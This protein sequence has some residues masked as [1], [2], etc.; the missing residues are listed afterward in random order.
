RAR[1]LAKAAEMNYRPNLNAR[2]LASRETHNIGV[3]LPMITNY[4]FSTVITGIQEVAWSHGYNIILYVTNDSADR[5]KLIATSLPLSSVD[6]L[7][8]C[9]SSFSDTASLY[10]TIIEQGTPVVFFDRIHI[11]VNTSKV[12]QDD[13]NGALIAIEHLIA[14]GYRRI[15]HISGPEGFTLTE[16]RKRGYLDALRN[17]NLPFDDS[18]IVHSGFSREDGEADTAQLLKLPNRPDAIFAVN[19][20]KGVG[21][22]Q[23]LTHRGIQAGAEVGVIGFTNDPVSTIISPTLSTVEEPA[24]DIGVQSCELLLRHVTKPHFNSELRTLGGK[25]IARESTKRNK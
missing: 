11:E 23:A 10:T 24:L 25:L 20:R 21:A 1:V 8:V 7:L 15:A 3:I 17:F 9:T 22:I 4:Y 13:Y 19:D 6:G 5:E 2:G 12:L 14:Q 16:N 18:W